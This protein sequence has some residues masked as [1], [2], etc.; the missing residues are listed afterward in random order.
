MLFTAVLCS[1][2]LC[3]DLHQPRP[4]DGPKGFRSVD[5]RYGGFERRPDPRGTSAAELFLCRRKI[6]QPEIGPSPFAF[7]FQ[8][9]IAVVVP[10]NRKGNGRFVS[11]VMVGGRNGMR[12]QV[13]EGVLLLDNSRQG[14]RY[15][16]AADR[17]GIAVLRLEGTQ[18]NNQ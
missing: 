5:G 13:N 10:K 8:N 4:P 1:I 16:G 12:G 3:P 9:Q 15:G 2:F 7:F 11:V 18:K 6:L 17:T 14:E